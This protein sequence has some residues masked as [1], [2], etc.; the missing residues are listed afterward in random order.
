MAINLGLANE[1]NVFVFGDMSMSNTDAE[2]RVA[3]GGNATLSNYGI[4][5]GISPLP[6]ANT[7]PSFVVDG[8]VNVSAGSN[9]SG[10]TVINPGST[11]LF[12][13]MGNPNGSLITGTPI[14]FAEAER[15]LKCA[16]AFWDS[17]PENGSG[18]VQFNQLNLIG[19]DQNLNIFRFDST[20]IYGTGLSLAQLNGINI[21]AP[22]ESTILIN[23]KGA[24]SSTAVTRYS[25]T[26]PAPR[27]KRHGRF[28][29]T[30]LTH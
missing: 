20:N 28:C 14:D 3:V 7:D 29:G 25:G 16:S 22:I 11:V 1:Y 15:Y 30:S 23:V 5:A 17:I 4:G 21:I 6:P 10:N 13:T 26:E 18:E 12:Y 24:T 19:T 8:D 9:A 27:G 2:G